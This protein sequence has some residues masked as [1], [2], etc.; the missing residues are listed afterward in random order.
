MDLRL[1]QEL[2][3][4]I[5]GTVRDY[6]YFLVNGIYPKWPIFISTISD[7]TPGSKDKLLATYQEA[8]RNDVERAFGVIVKRFDIL[9]RLIRF[10]RNDVIRNVLHTCI[11]LHNMTVNKQRKDYVSERVYYHYTPIDTVEEDLLS[12]FRSLEIAA[13]GSVV[14]EA[15]GSR[16]YQI[17]AA[18]HNELEHHGLMYDLKEHIWSKSNNSN[19]I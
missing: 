9:S 5:N 13:D 14:Q 4:C 8:V 18:L 16:L 6:L 10:W 17:D 1:P 7:A 11:V 12:L 3:Y 2:H 19:I 15:I